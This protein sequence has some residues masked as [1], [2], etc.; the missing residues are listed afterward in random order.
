[1]NGRVFHEPHMGAAMMRIVPGGA[2]F[3]CVRFTRET[4]VQTW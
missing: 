2:G 4:A 3:A 1:M